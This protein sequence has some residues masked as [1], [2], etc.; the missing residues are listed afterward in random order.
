MS[1]LSIS[2]S[3]GQTALSDQQQQFNTLVGRIAEERAQLARW[4]EAVSAYQQRY[5]RELQPLFDTYYGLHAELVQWLD[6]DAAIGMGL[7]KSAHRTLE[8]VIASMAGYLARSVHDDA[9]RAAMQ[10]LHA[11][12]RPADADDGIPDT[13]DDSVDAAESPEADT[14]DAA[15]DDSPEAILERVEA[16][17]RADQARVEEERHRHRAQRAKKPSARERSEKEAALQASQ[18]VRAI[19]R[20][21]ASALHPDREPD[22]AQRD[23]KTVLM[24][25]VNQAYAA[26][27]LLDLLQLQLE[28]EQIDPDHLTRLGDERL[29]HYNQVLSNQLTE[30]QEETRNIEQ[31]FRSQFGLAPHGKLSPKSLAAHLRGQ[32]QQLQSEIADLRMQRG[33][34][35]HPAELK[36]WLK[37][38]RAALRDLEDGWGGSD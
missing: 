10:A 27:N 7:S 31:G 17:M 33:A 3:Q 26:N 24:Q 13:P 30:L 4:N 34:L 9:T 18:S 5:A 22:P 12:Y 32:A 14:G 19:Y 6:R 38:Q 16:Q 35:E 8:E 25:R 21:L 11:K 29:T 23:R 28:A 20:K 2:E 37:A 36:R 1:R 15:Q